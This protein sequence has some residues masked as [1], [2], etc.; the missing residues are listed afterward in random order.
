MYYGDVDPDK[1]GDVGIDFTDNV[2]PLLHKNGQTEPLSNEWDAISAWA[3]ELCRAM[4]YFE[5]DDD[6]VLST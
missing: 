3:W 2:H 5:K 1:F 6:I 4:D